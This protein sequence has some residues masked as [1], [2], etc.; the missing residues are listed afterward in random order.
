M[1]PSPLLNNTLEASRRELNSRI[2]ASSE[3]LGRE[4]TVQHPLLLT[5]PS[6]VDGIEESHLADG[7]AEENQNGCSSTP[8]R[9]LGLGVESNKD[10]EIVQNEQSAAQDV[11]R[12]VARHPSRVDR[13]QTDR[14]ISDGGFYA[15]SI[16]GDAHL[17]RR[18][19]SPAIAQTSASSTF[20][21]DTALVSN[22]SQHYDPSSG[23]SSSLGR[24]ANWA[25]KNDWIRISTGH[26]E[27]KTDKAGF[28]DCVL[29][30]EYKDLLY[31]KAISELKSDLAA[32]ETILAARDVDL[33][34]LEEDHEALEQEV[35]GL[36]SQLEELE[37]RVEAQ[38]R[39]LR[40]AE[41]KGRVFEKANGKLTREQQDLHANNA[42]LENELQQARA[43][44]ANLERQN[45]QAALDVGFFAVQNA[46]YRSE[47]EDSDPARTALF[48]GIIQRKDE[49]IVR[50]EDDVH[51]C[52]AK[53]A[54][55]EKRR[56]ME[57][58]TTACAIEG[59]EQDLKDRT[60]S[61]DAI[62]LSRDALQEQLDYTAEM[63]K[64]KIY[65]D[66]MVKAICN[67]HDAISQDNAFLITALQKR[68]NNIRK[69]KQD[70]GLS[71]AETIEVRCTIEA[72]KQENAQLNS[73]ISHQTQRIDELEWRIELHPQALEDAKAP[74]INH[75]RTL[76]DK[77][78]Q[79]RTDHTA[80]LSHSLEYTYQRIL[81]EKDAKIN[82]LQKSIE[83]MT[84]TCNGL[85]N[86]VLELGGV[87][88]ELFDH[89]VH[90]EEIQDWRG[91]EFKR[92]LRFA[93][94]RLVPEQVEW[95]QKFVEKGPL[96]AWMET[97]G[98]VREEE[99]GPGARGGQ[100]MLTADRT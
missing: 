29:A 86:E 24:A 41:N 47:M 81:A 3:N 34:N 76:T 100:K 78:D 46:F 33:A 18:Y 43:T 85:Y 68:E 90:C 4:Q 7:R 73:K 42:K 77:N 40:H 88:G 82:Q 22:T 75:I 58:V 80:L 65:H 54:E 97:C 10:E 96:R 11:P 25:Q 30:V 6:T 32:T 94:G 17:R 93:E 5:P 67:S 48:D 53:L 69:T 39:K 49:A 8:A 31:H 1:A 57:R 99:E 2:F 12:I 98:P 56:A 26:N 63:F 66:D 83:K 59:L 52:Y 70:L 13:V 27:G 95:A 15:S 72:A 64:S 71:K 20:E 91:E 35:T 36:G 79:L 74:Y 55:E 19:S 23:S 92:R 38:G 51:V 9:R 28:N 84:M 60:A 21:S 14:T 44:N 87:N 50:L 62:T 45:R 89:D 37:A 61:I 16:K